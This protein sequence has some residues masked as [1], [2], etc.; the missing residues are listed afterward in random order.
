VKLS[1]LIVASLTAGLVLGAAARAVMRFVA[2]ESGIDTGYSLGGSLEVVAFGVLC[3]APVALLFFALHPRLAGERWWL[4]GPTVSA[5]LFAGLW[6]VPP[7]AAQSALAGTPDTPQATAAAFAALLGAWGV[8]LEWAA[9]R[10]FASSPR[11]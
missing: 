7:P 6:L 8:W 5:A 1:R 10:W 2:L 3:G 9:R 11:A 4:R